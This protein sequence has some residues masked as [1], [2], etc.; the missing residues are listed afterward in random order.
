MININGLNKAD[1]LASLYNCSHAQGWSWLAKEKHPGLMTREEAQEILDSGQTDFDYL[2]G[3]VMKIDLD[4]ECF[5]E[6]L[7]DRE[8][9]PGRAQFAVDLVLD[10]M[11]RPTK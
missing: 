5:D 10:E 11:T 1:V 2:C 7:Y 8:N 6:R 9:G 4:G 3:H